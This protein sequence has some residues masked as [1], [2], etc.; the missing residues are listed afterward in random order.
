MI[1]K[2]YLYDISD[3]KKVLTDRLLK[4]LLPSKC[5]LLIIFDRNT[6]D[7]SHG[8]PW[9]G[10]IPHT[11]NIEIDGNHEN[12]P[13]QIQR[14]TDK[15]TEERPDHLIWIPVNI[16]TADDRRFCWI[17]AHELQH[18]VQ[19]HNHK[20]IYITYKLFKENL[21]SWMNPITA[22]CLDIP[23]E[24]DA[25]LCARRKI[26]ELFGTECRNYHPEEGNEQT[27]SRY[28]EL[29]DKFMSFDLQ[30]TY[31]LKNEI[32]ILLKKYRIEIEDIIQKSIW[33]I[34][35]IN[36]DNICNEFS[37]RQLT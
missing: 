32:V 34:S 15:L 23:H 31:D 30:N 22:C 26:I 37:P 28:K 14:L 8:D 25:D 17:L 35:G 5:K 12:P 18:T 21:R 10:Q 19:D 27:A 33:P 1:E 2:E 13:E 6:Y 29:K 9:H 24:F 36:I 7:S 20:Y 4:V 11:K 16:C 3:Q